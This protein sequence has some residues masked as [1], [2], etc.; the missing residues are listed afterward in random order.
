MQMLARYADR[1]AGAFE[2]HSGD[3]VPRSR[4]ATSGIA[5]AQVGHLHVG[6]QTINRLYAARGQ[7]DTTRTS[8]P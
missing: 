1:Q 8:R 5:V 2:L 6:T 3:P 7:P 4:A